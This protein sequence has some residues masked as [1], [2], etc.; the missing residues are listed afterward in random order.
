MERKIQVLT[1]IDDLAE[2]IQ[3]ARIEQANLHASGPYSEL[4][5]ELT[6]A[7]VECPPEKRGL[8]QR[9]RVPWTKSRLTLRHITAATVTPP[10]DV[11]LNELP[12]VSAESA[13]GGYQVIVKTPEGMQ[14]IL[15]ADQL[16]GLFADVGT[17]I[18]SP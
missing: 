14:M 8:F 4:S 1:D 17:P 13:A 3:G 6:R 10:T 18:E 15:T 5:L 12:V 9:L 16:D 7:M 2:L 11:P